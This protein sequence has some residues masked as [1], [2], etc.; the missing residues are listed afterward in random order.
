MKSAHMCVVTPGR[1]GLYET[2]RELVVALRSTG[3][4]ARIIDVPSA[5][6]VYP[7]GYPHKWDRK[8]PI[9]DMKWAQNADVIVNHSGYDGTPIEKTNQPVVHVAH[10][11]P[12]S[13]YL[14]QEGGG[15]PILTYH[16]NKNL[17]PRWKAVVTFW[18]EHVPF[19][20]TMFPDV[21]VVYVPSCVDLEA[22][23][24]GESDYDFHG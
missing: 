12:R 21:P 18:E 3:V 6:K 4:D 17:D 19:H 7:K 22:W 20:E 24:P 16:H 2:T 13:S 15:T 14:T 5:N 1:C 10:G 9:A 8:A 11:R 23:S